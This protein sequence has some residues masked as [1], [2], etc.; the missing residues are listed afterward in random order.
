M[1]RVLTASIIDTRNRLFVLLF[2]LC[3]VTY[4]GLGVTIALQ[5]FDDFDTAFIASVESG[6]RASY[7]EVTIVVLPARP[8]PQSAYYRP[9][10][11]YR[12]E[13]LLM[14]LDSTKDASHTK[15]VGL[16]ATDISTTRGKHYDWGIFGYGG[17]SAAPCVV[18]T[19]RLR[20]GNADRKRVTERLV[21]V[22][23][24]ELGHTFGLVHCATKGCL[25]A[26]AK[27]SIGPVDRSDGMLCAGCRNLLSVILGSY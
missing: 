2:L 11:R 26:D 18:S 20:G 7:G 25:M 24:H 6:I 14:F 21:K 4:A 27:G 13:K 3:S 15:I 22:V 12:A 9:R 23:N 10:N 16:T 17:I 8:L 5:P 1:T 19:F